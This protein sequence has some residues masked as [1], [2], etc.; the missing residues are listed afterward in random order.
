MP[1]GIETIPTSGPQLR[2]KDWLMAPLLLLAGAVLLLLVYLQYNWPGTWISSPPPLSWKG[3]VMNLS[4]GQGGSGEGSVTIEAVGEQG[5]AVVSLTPKVFR[6]KDYPAVSWNI[7]GVQPGAELVFLWRT[8]ENSSRVFTRPLAVAKNGV[9]PLE[10]AGDE[11]WRGQI[12][13]LALMVKGQL[14]A[15]IIVKGVSLQPASARIALAR[16]VERWLIPEGWQATSINFLDGDALEQDVPLAPAIAALVLLAVGLYLTLAKI[17]FVSLHAAVLWSMVF[18]GWFVLDARWQ[19][20]LFKQLDATQHQYA[21]KS[22]EEKHLAAE[23]GALF[24]FMRQVKAKLPAGTGRILY[25]SDDAFSRAK[26]A[27]YLY[28]HNVMASPNSSG[29]SHLKSGDFIVLFGKKDVQYDAA[30]QS[31][32]WEGVQPLRTDLLLSAAGNLLL[33]VH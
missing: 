27:Y 20:N 23:D 8:V 21:G 13:G 30:R 2:R 14:D 33:K 1:S 3:S 7:A 31:M 18:L 11:N 5:V 17:K 6:A 25:L 24:D 9:L 12:I 26:G 15:P 22:W 19:W 29:L 32:V 16:M 28:P 10:M 4:K